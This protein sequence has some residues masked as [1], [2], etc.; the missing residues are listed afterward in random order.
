MKSNFIFNLFCLK[1]LFAFSKRKTVERDFNSFFPNRN[2]FVLFFIF[3]FLMISNCKESEADRVQRIQENYKNQIKTQYIIANSS[4]SRIGA[5][6]IF[7][8]EIAA[9]KLPYSICDEKESKEILFPN[10]YNSNAL[11]SYEEPNRAW[12]I[13]SERQNFGIQSLIKKL[14]GITIKDISIE[15]RKDI[16]DLNALKGHIV[17]NIIV[18]TSSNDI[19]IDEIKLIIEHRNQFKVCVVSK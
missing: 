2:Y 12:S 4:N 19:E 18:K 15:W 10:S 1:S 6:V 9:N 11:I 8:K 5:A 17:Q 16:R 7:L 13:V 3:S 14:N